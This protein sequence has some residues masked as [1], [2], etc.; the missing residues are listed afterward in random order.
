MIAP[1]PES[2][3]AFDDT[4]EAYGY[5]LPEERIARYPGERGASR[6]MLLKRGEGHTHHMFAAL[7]ELL[8]EG[9]LLVANNSRVLPARLLGRRPTGG[10][11][12]CLLLTPL[13]LIRPV[14]AGGGRM[15][16]VEALLKPSRP[17]R[18]GFRFDLDGGLAATVLEKGAFGHCRLRLEWTGDLH[19]LVERHGRLPLPPYMRREADENDRRRYQTVYAR[20]DKTGSVAAPTAGLHFTPAMRGRLLDMGFAWAEV[21]LH[22]GYGTFSPVREHDIRRHSLHGEYVEISAHAAT[23]VNQARREGRPVVAVGTTSAR[24]LE[25]V[26]ALRGG[27]LAAHAG[28]IDMFIRP[29]HVFQIVSGLITNFHLPGSSLL[30][31]VSALAGRQAVLDAYRDAVRSGY[32]FFSYGDAMLVR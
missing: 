17:A 3:I 2:A 6:L 10:A 23:A 24:A 25:G 30:M 16:V 20:M 32:A 18:P 14:V 7:P 8:P 12:A 1:G 13:P 11:I 28:P 27:S 4:L 22:V 15:A 29:G 31:L 21:T 9:A 26:A 19:D 5:D